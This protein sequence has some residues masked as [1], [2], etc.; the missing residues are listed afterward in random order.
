MSSAASTSPF[1]MTI[2]SVCVV[3]GIVIL[4]IVWRR[5]KMFRIEKEGFNL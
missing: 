1:E 3:V 4:G 2:P 5:M